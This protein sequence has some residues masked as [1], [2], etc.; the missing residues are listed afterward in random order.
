MAWYWWVAIVIGYL[1]VGTLTFSYFSDVALL[2]WSFSK[3]K[4]LQ[5]LR[6]DIIF[7]SFW[8]WPITL[9]VCLIL[10]F[11]WLMQV[12]LEGIVALF[13]SKPR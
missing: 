7:L 13:S 9:A 5:W 12:I 11:P 1:I 2:D 10:F 4:K 6:T 3:N 8:L